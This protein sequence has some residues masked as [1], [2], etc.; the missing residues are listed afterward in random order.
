M[1]A[2]KRAHSDK[3]DAGAYCAEI[4]YQVHGEYPDQKSVD[5]IYEEPD[6][7]PKVALEAMEDAGSLTEEKLEDVRRRWHEAMEGK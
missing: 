3:D 5:E 7:L 2:C 4:H 6:Q 1:G